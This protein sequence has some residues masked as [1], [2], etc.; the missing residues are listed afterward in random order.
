MVAD[1][2][3]LL[4][5]WTF[6]PIVILIIF[7]LG[8]LYWTGSRSTY[9]FESSPRLRLF[10]FSLF[11]LFITL[12]SPIN[13]LAPHFFFMRVLQ[14]ILLLSLFVSTFMNSDPFVVMYAGLPKRFTPYVDRFTDW[15]Y[16]SLETYFTKGTC[17]F[18]FIMSVWIW[19]DFS[20]VDLTLTRPWLR[21]VE[22][23]V[24]L[25]GALLHWWHVTAATPKIH[26]RLPSFAHMGYT[27]AGAGPLKIPG[28]FFLFSIT[29]LYGYS[30]ATFLGWELDT[31]TSQSIGG[32]II[33]MIGGT[34]YTINSAR[35]FSR[36]LDTE[37]AKP[38]RPLS[39]WDNDEV[40]RAPHLD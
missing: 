21:N 27:L 32:G 13:T 6:R 29:P 20:I 4:T 19:Y 38:P 3:M 8:W 2:N 36:W 25:V 12:C 24:M 28:L 7:V 22:L 23:S 16:P 15:L 34:V 30:E 5:A 10:F 9:E 17:W 14:H 33:W 31:V 26:P 18:I 39:D 1:W 11:S 35:Y 40:F 37:T